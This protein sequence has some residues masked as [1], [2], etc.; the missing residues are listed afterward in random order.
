MQI[1]K[2][3]ILEMNFQGYHGQRNQKQFLVMQNAVHLYPLKRSNGQM[4]TFWAVFCIKERKKMDFLWL[5]VRTIINH[6]DL[7]IKYA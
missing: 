4:Q 6:M 2:H 5:V 7:K 1:C 3:Y